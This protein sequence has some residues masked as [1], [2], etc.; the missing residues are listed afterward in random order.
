LD[1]LPA[2]AAIEELLACP[3]VTG[4]QVIELSKAGELPSWLQ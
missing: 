3:D 2:E 4:A 1:A